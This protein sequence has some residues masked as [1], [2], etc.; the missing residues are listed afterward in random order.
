M[1]RFVFVISKVGKT[2]LSRYYEAVEDA[3]RTR[4]RKELE[5]MVS[6][7]RK[8]P[9]TAIKEWDQYK[10]VMRRYASLTI[11]FCL[12]FKSNELLALEAIHHFVETLD[13]YFGSVCELDLICNVS[14][15]Y[16]V[17][18]Q[19]IIDGVVQE[20]VTNKTSVQRVLA[21]HNDAK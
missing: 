12:D 15:A 1:I 3:E 21:M 11:I 13:R 20:G 8:S 4:I 9:S 7:T 18:D 19:L 6:T 14:A 2:R 16:Y 10:L 5:L 17:L